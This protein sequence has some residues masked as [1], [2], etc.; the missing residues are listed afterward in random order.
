MINSNSF[1]QEHQNESIIWS[2]EEDNEHNQSFLRIGLPPSHYRSILPTT[3][4]SPTYGEQQDDIEIV[5]IRPLN[6]LSAFN[7]DCQQ[8]NT[9]RLHSK[10][11]CSIL[12]LF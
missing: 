6:N 7:F 3:I 5:H 8:M 10:I 4:S 12:Y 1:G 9:E 11:Q 2:D